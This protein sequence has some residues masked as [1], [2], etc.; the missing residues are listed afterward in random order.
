MRAVPR[1]LLSMDEKPSCAPMYT[2]CDLGL[3]ASAIG[4]I[5]RAKVARSQHI[6]A[7]EIG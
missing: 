4:A 7:L 3:I 5:N 6:T 1:D 2:Q